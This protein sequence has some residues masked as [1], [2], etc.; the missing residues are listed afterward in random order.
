M[1]EI[2][3]RQRR[4]A[5]C[6]SRGRAREDGRASGTEQEPTERGLPSLQIRHVPVTT[7]N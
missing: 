5:E 3:W 6:E 4:A 2:G 1:K 7:T